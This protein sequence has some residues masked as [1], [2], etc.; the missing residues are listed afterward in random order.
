ML[1]QAIREAARGGP[2]VNNSLPTHV[3]LKVRE[4]MFEFMATPTYEFLRRVQAQSSRVGDPFAGPVRPL[5]V[6]PD[7]AGHDCALGFFAAL[8]E[9]LVHER[10]VEAFQG[11]SVFN[12]NKAVKT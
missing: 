5:S 1:E 7:L 3:D 6:E 4:R 9:A 11:G 10:L 2:E 8:A 12:R